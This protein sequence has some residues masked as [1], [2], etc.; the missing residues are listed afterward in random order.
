[1]IADPDFKRNPERIRVKVID[2]YIDP[3]GGGSLCLELEYRPADIHHASRFF[4]MR[5]RPH[6]S[7]DLLETTPT[8][9][10]D[11]EDE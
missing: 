6:S 2:Q 7:F 3:D 8:P 5:L 11:Y 10:D 4:L 9:V 1:M